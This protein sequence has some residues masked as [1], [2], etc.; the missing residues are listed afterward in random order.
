MELKQLLENV[1]VVSPMFDAEIHDICTESSQLKENSLFLITGE[2]RHKIVPYENNMLQSAILN[3]TGFILWDS[4]NW[5]KHEDSRESHRYIAVKH[6]RK[7][8]AQICSNF[9]GQPSKNLLMI[10]VTG[11]NGK[12]STTL[13]IE[14]ILEFSK[15]YRPLL[16]GTLFA[17][18]CGVM[19]QPSYTT[20]YCDIIQKLLRTAIDEYQA[21]SAVMEI[22]SRGLEQER[23]GGI[24]FDVSIYT[25]LTHDHLS[26]HTTFDE[27]K[28][29]KTT[30]FEDLTKSFAIINRDDDYAQHFIDQTKKTA[31]VMTYGIA[32]NHDTDIYASNIQLSVHGLNFDIN[33]P[34]TNIT[35]HIHIPSLVGKTNVYNSLAALACAH[36]TLNIPLDLCKDALVNMPPIPGRLEFVTV[37]EDPITVIIDSAHTPD[38]F[39]EILNTIRDCT[40]SNNLLCLFGC[41]GDIDHA[42]RS[43]KAAVARQLSDTVIVTT[44]TSASED[45]KQIIQDILVG[46]S[47]TS[48]S[49]D[50]V[51]IEIDRRKAIEK[52]ILSVM[53]DGDT[54]VILG[55]RHDINRML[56]NRIIDFDDR[57]IVRECIKQRIQR[58][59]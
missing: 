54:L 35:E 17:R 22:S 2:G 15:L 56:Q 45:P 23:V 5:P 55:K 49:D 11:T 28:R 12:T 43:I 3:R 32:R 16:I 18:C 24:A 52:A 29:T 20:P 31:R 4:E 26:Y 40:L 34:A 58:N 9:Y 13:L 47:S 38:G 7:S 25:N 39:K 10:G 30:L 19:M 44:D 37:P 21:D 33:I 14:Q 53:Q 51:I 41:R 57:V 42:N 48:N 59:S 6:Y 1:D 36:L 27:Y 50:N 8:C 46:F